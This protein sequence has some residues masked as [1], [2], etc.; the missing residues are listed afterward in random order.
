MRARMVPFL[1]WVR[2]QGLTV[3]LRPILFVVT[4]LNTLAPFFTMEEG[5]RKSWFHGNIRPQNPEE[6]FA[7]FKAYHDLYLTIARLAQVEFYTLGAELYSMTVGIEGE[8]KEYPE[9]FPKNWSQLLQYARKQLP[10][11]TKIMYDLTYTDDYGHSVVRG[12][13][14]ERWR[15]RLVDLPASSSELREFWSSLDAIG[16]DMYRSLGSGEELVPQNYPELVKFLRQTSDRYAKELT[17]S[18]SQIE[19]TLKIKK[20][21]ILKE[22]GFRSSQLSFLNPF[23][24]DNPGEQLNLEHQAAAYEAFLESFSDPKLQW[25]GGMAFWDIGVSPKRRGEQDNGFTPVGKPHTE[26]VIKRYYQ[27]IFSR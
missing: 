24:Y 10:A 18:L 3:Q 26:A 16:V 15:H 12:G 1:Q 27:T 14:F 2:R 11:K 25:L 19:T 5:Q 4:D 8:W 9:G 23:A 7:S 13:E 21:V 22:V 6:W 17:A 20:S